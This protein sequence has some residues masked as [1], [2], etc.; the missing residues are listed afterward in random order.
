MKQTILMTAYAVNPWKGSE[1]GTGWNWILQAAGEHN[2][3]AITR[4]NNRAHIERYMQE[5]LD[6]RYENIEFMYFDLPYWMRFWKKGTVGALIYF[7]LWQITMPI[8]IL[9]KQIRFDISHNLNFHNDWIPSFLWVFPKPLVWGPVGHHPMIPAKYMRHYPWK[10]F[11]VDRLSYVAKTLVSRLDIFMYMNVLFADK[12][13]AINSDVQKKYPWARHK[14]TIVPA[15]GGKSVSV[16]EMPSN[17][18]VVFSAGRF[19]ALKGFDLAVHAYGKFFQQLSEQEKLRVQFSIAGSGTCEKI[20]RNIAEEYQMGEAINFI[21][22]IPKEKINQYYQQ[23]SVFLFPSHEGAGMVIPEAL[24]NGL[25][26]ICLQNQGP[27]ESTND[28]CAFRITYS[29]YNQTVLDLSKALRTLFYNPST[30]DAMKRASMLHFDR[31]F[32]WN[33]KGIQ[34]KEIYQ[35]LNQRH[36]VKNSVRPSL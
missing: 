32:D 16:S 13:I 24:S 23:A 10:Y 11:L 4:K 6:A 12:I 21:E 27:G 17:K 29:D 8:F 35:Q 3:I 31:V 19:E 22:W 14:I 36:A 5:R 7:Y 2:V 33:N 30:R 26:V 28:A 18:F 20:L 34:L 15:I 1:D 9:S 25:P